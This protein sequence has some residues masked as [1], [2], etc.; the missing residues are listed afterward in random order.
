MS[1]QERDCVSIRE[2]LEKA[3]ANVRYFA[4]GGPEG[5]LDEEEIRQAADWGE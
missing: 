4:C 5:E 2:G 3:G 1:W